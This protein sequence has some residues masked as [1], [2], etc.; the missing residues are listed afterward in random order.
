MRISI[1]VVLLCLASAAGATPRQPTNIAAQQL[2]AA[3]QI[4][5]REHGVQVVYRSELVGAHRTSG[6]TGYLTLE[7]ALAQLLTG[8]GLTYA[9]LGERAITIVQSASM[10]PSN[11][12]PGP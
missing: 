8:T 2:G 12:V 11:E 9:W 10:Q 1:A 6:A 7:E 5:A 3:L 4:L